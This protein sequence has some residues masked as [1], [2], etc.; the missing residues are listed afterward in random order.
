M[1][2]CKLYLSFFIINIRVLYY[3]RFLL[4]R[5]TTFFTK[6]SEGMKAIPLFLIISL[7]HIVY[8]YNIFS[9]IT[10]TSCHK[11]ISIQII[12]VKVQK[13]KKKHLKCISIQIILVKVQKNKKASKKIRNINLIKIRYLPHGPL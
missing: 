7:I 10:W 6:W 8:N 3:K 5:T 11:C 13:N 4:N 12:L 9:K 1:I 2:R